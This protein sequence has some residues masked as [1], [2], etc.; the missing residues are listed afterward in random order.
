MAQPLRK[1]EYYTYAD[2]CKWD[3]DLRWELI[4]GYRMQWLRRLFG[5]I[6]GSKRIKLEN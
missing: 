1:E 4:D 3:D 6:N 5:S 2:Y